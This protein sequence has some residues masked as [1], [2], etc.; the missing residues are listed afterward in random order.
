MATK[1]RNRLWSKT[2][3]MTIGKYSVSM[4]HLKMIY[5]DQNYAKFDHKLTK[6]DLD[7]K[8]K[9]NF[10]CCLRLAS[11][12]LLDIVRKHGAMKGTFFI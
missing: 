4:D 12:E 6:S 5:D 1:W 7:P 9:E 8:D 11:N 3:E 10:H 2:A